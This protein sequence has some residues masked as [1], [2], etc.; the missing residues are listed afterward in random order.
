M[1]KNST[2]KEEKQKTLYPHIHRQTNQNF[3]N[4]MSVMKLNCFK[5]TLKA[6]TMSNKFF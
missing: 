1:K 3:N 5:Q 2:H 4:K 6:F